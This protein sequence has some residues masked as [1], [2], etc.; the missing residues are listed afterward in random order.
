MFANS[1]VYL[2]PLPPLCLHRYY[3][4]LKVTIIFDDDVDV[5][6]CVRKYLDRIEMLPNRSVFVNATWYFRGRCRGYHGLFGWMPRAN[7]P[8]YVANAVPFHTNQTP[9]ILRLSISFAHDLADRQ[10]LWTLKKCEMDL[11]KF[12][13]ASYRSKRKQMMSLFDKRYMFEFI[14][15]K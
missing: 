15:S 9:S 5:E 2:K 8:T 10:A 12:V 6:M 3:K 4:K 13:S 11:K 1:F 14:E 7:I